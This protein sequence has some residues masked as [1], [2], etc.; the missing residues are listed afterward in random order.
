M[1]D[2]SYKDNRPTTLCGTQNAKTI[3]GER[4]G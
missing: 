2:L 1:F 3:K 4:L